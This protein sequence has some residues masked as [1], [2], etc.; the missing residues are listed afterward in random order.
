[1]TD[2]EKVVENRMRRIA[3]RRGYTLTKNRVRDP[4][5]VDYGCYYLCRD[6]VLVDKYGSL[7][8]VARWLPGVTEHEFTTGG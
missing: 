1:M 6:G 2:A 3:S 4:F 8:E 7:S 5:A